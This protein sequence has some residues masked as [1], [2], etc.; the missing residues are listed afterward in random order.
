M[1]YL[2]RRRFLLAGAAA[3]VAVVGFL[4]L[5]LL[6]D[7]PAPSKRVPVT[8]LEVSPPRVMLGHPVTI[9]GIVAAPADAE[10]QY[11]VRLTINGRVIETREVRVK[12][13]RPASVVFAH[14]PLR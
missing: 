6:P 10:A 1:R 2:L 14:T 13:R 9:T 5:A 7:T 3:A 12:S 4:T 8:S 11:L